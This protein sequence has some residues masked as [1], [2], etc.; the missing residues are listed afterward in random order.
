MKAKFLTIAFV[1]GLLC[2]APQMFAQQYNE[3]YL[4]S[5]IKAKTQ[6]QA[7]SGSKFI[8][9]GYAT[10]GIQFTKE[11]SSF[12]ANFSPIFLWKPDKRVF[13]E[14]ELETELEGEETMI[15]LE[16]I[17]ASF[18][19]NKYVTLRAGK[20]LS[21]F[22][23]FQD[24]LHPGWINKLPSV[25]LGFNHD[26]NPV[27][28]TS[29]IGFDLRGNDIPLGTAKFNYSL[30]V[31]NGP[32]LNTG[33]ENP[34]E[35]G[36]LHYA[37]AEDNNKNKAFGGRIGLLPFSNSS[38]EIGGSF[39]TAKVGDK[40]N[41]Y[42]KVGAQLYA[43]DLTYVNQLDFLKGNLDVKAQWNWINVDKAN[44]I[45]PQD[46]TGN[47][48]YSYDN[49][50]SAAFAQAAYR[51]NMSQSKF[52]KKT[53]LVFR[54]SGLNPPVGSMASEKIKQYTYGINYWYTWRTVLKLAYQ[55]QKDNNAFFI[56]VAVGF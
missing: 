51:P 25:P 38:V 21:P 45:D 29:E 40:G 54:Y 27:G 15:N 16:Y 34:E 53:E 9:T 36:V 52:L 17:D 22:G 28:A 47:T 49:K 7:A 12:G 41:E 56:Q 3:E 6:A 31:S 14:A 4:D 37:S 42:E 48:F 10:T 50:R 39:Q 2:G 26:Q 46:S 20:F 55:S 33:D 43:L 13:I 18:F 24:R 1:V 30:Y 32:T 35:A 8:L 19:I 23:I 5:L 11:E 44:Y